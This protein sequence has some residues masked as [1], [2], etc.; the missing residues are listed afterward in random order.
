VAPTFFPMA[1][2]VAKSME[3]HLA[4]KDLRK[5]ATFLVAKNWMEKVIK[6]NL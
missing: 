4:I 3:R 2:L 6:E 1:D 5:L